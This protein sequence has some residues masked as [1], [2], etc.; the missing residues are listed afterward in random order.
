MAPDGSGTHFFSPKAGGIHHRA[1]PGA[2]ALRPPARPSAAPKRSTRPGLARP[3][4]APPAPA[5]RALPRAL[6]TAWPRRTRARSLS[7]QSAQPGPSTMAAALS[8]RSALPASP[9]QI[10]RS[11]RGGAAAPGPPR[12]RPGER[13]AATAS[14]HWRL[15]GACAPGGVQAETDRQVSHWQPG[16]A[17]DAPAGL[18]E[19]WSGA[20][21][22]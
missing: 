8:I 22:A 9:V 18:G 12:L 19:R 13:R 15:R 2:Q 20:G 4:T 5:D 3:L 11:L 16:A 10:C 17:P 6:R 1:A 21:A 14:C 7:A